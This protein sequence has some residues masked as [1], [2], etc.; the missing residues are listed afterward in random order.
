[1]THRTVASTFGD[2]AG[3]GIAEYLASRGLIPTSIA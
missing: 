3:S 1:M 2:P